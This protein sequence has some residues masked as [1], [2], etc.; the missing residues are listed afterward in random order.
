[1]LKE[2]P[3]DII[4]TFNE[5][6]SYVINCEQ[7]V[8]MYEVDWQDSSGNPI[9]ALQGFMGTKLYKNFESDSE[10][11]RMLYVFNGYLYVVSG[12]YVYQVSSNNN[13]VYKGQINSYY[14][15]IYQ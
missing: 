7:T 13:S 14:P 15:E 2:I 5:L 3:I 1:M 8:N 12:E 6:D 10:N 9:R 11:I 4:G